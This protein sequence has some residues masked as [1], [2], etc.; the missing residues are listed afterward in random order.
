MTIYLVDT[1]GVAF[2]K[3]EDAV[4]FVRQK[5]YN[6]KKL[7]YYKEAFGAT[8]SEESIVY[9]VNNKIREVELQ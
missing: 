4:A 8:H 5:E 1:Y 9:L 7:A 2:K 3:R 6:E